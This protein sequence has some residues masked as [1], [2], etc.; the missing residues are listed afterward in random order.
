MKRKNA[1]QFEEKESSPIASCSNES[2]IK[3]KDSKLM[4]QDASELPDVEIPKRR[5]FF[6]FFSRRAENGGQDQENRKPR[7]SSGFRNIFFI[8]S[9][10]SSIEY[11]NEVDKKASK[12]K[13]V[14]NVL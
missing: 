12:K 13:S 6:S 14:E 3:D 7:K 8:S 9:N 11:Q 1:C 2:A 5:S 10:S 4:I